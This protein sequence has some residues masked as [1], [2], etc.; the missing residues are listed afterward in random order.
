M[1]ELERKIVTILKDPLY[2]IEFLENWTGRDDNVIKKAKSISMTKSNYI[3]KFRFQFIRR[4]EQS[5]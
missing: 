2:T 5:L 3:C 1:N 4:M